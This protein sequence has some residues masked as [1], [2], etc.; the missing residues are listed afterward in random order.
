[1]LRASAQNKGLSLLIHVRKPEGLR[2]LKESL[3]ETLRK[4]ILLEI[5]KCVIRQISMARFTLSDTKRDWVR[6]SNDLYRTEVIYIE[7]N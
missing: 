2:L 4:V 6:T 3:S 1:M 5:D 7:L